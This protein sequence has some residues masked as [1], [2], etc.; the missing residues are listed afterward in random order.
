MKRKLCVNECMCLPC[1][2]HRIDSDLEMWCDWHAERVTKVIN[3]PA[4]KDLGHEYSLFRDI[5]I[6]ISNHQKL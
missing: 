6:Y 4:R 2:H 5:D 3:C 1:P